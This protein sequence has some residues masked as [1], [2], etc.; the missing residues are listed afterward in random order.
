MDVKRRQLIIGMTSMIGAAALD[1]FGLL[2]VSSAS[3]SE[4]LEH[5][6]EKV[7]P[8]RDIKD[9]PHITDVIPSMNMESYFHII[10]D[11]CADPK[12][13]YLSRIPFL[14]ELE[15]SKIWM[16]SR[17]EWNALSSSGAAGLQQFMEDTAKEYELT[18]ADSPEIQKLK[19]AIS[20]Y[21]LI[22]N[23]AEAKTRG[24]YK[25]VEPDGG[26]I[27]EASLAEINRLRAEIRDLYTNRA[28]AYEALKAAKAEYVEKIN[29]I[30]IE[31]RKEFDARFVPE[32]AIPPGVD[33]TVKNIM[34]CKAVFGG[35]VEIN[36]WR[37]IAAYNAGLGAAKKWQGMPYIQETVYYTRGVIT[38]LTKSL[39]LKDA[40][41]TKDISLIAGTKRRLGLG[42]MQ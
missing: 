26:D 27:T 13:D 14:I 15:A 37:G 18:I 2:R 33:H 11:S 20:E 17:F 28:T 39:E 8:S 23:D 10:V 3:Q 35:P 30:P 29:S 7:S 5:T 16:E 42:D 22:R 36:V 38:N 9:Y 6:E 21:K 25:L 31:Q 19:A 1:G 24:L 40:Y 34:E 4:Q 12:K 41:A 32:L